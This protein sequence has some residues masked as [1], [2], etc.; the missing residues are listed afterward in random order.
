MKNNLIIFLW[1]LT[2]S[3]FAQNFQLDWLKEQLSQHPAKDSIRVNILIQIADMYYSMDEHDMRV[4]HLK[5]A[6]QNALELD[7]IK[8]EI[9][10][11][12]HI[13]ETYLY[14]DNF[15]LAEEYTLIAL[16]ESRNNDNWML[17]EIITGQAEIELRKGNYQTSIELTKEVLASAR[18]KG[19][20][21]VEIISLCNIADCM[22]RLKQY[23]EARTIL[24]KCQAMTHPDNLMSGNYKML[25]LMI[26]LDS[27]T[28]NFANA[29][30][31]QRQL[32]MLTAKKFLSG[33]LQKTSDE[34]LQAE[35]Q[36]LNMKLTDLQSTGQAQKKQ[37]AKTNSILI[38]LVFVVCCGALFFAW[39]RHSSQKLRSEKK[40]LIDEKVLAIEKKDRLSDKYQTLSQNKALLQKTNDRLM[41]SDRSK[42]ELFKIISHDL[43][44]PLIRLQQNLIELMKDINENQFRQVSAELM[45]MVGDLSLLLEN[46]LQW[47]KYQSQGIHAKPQYTEVTALVN[48]IVGNQKYN[49]A[50]KRIAISNA[51]EQNIFVYADEEMVKSLLKIIFQN[52]VKL[53]EP[54]AMITI[55]GDKDKHNGWL[56][57][58]YAGQMPLKRTFLQQMQA[59]KY[60]SETTELNKAIILGWMLCRTLVNANNGNICVEDISAESFQIILYFQLEESVKKNRQC[61][62]NHSNPLHFHPV[63]I[64]FDQVN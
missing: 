22:I 61:G 47:S 1:L 55:C 29:F 10:I 62:Q 32:E 28:G 52:I 39:L 63:A 27:A 43:Q 15:E 12:Y 6:L 24:E 35:L 53:S 3:C 37:T 60:G 7:N 23:R 46:L 56:Q 14:L 9:N 13:S 48:D 33:Q 51:L 30:L 17:D 54:G 50:E 26:A 16:E 41:V 44:T 20:T 64:S 18:D 2:I 38:V 5:K 42:T 31:K 36:H 40:Q 4:L 45:N 59:V 58:N 11:L 25:Q 8:L 21:Q 57:V 19:R 34:E 49:A